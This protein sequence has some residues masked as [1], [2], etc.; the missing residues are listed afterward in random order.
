V[1]G[2]T[3]VLM[4]PFLIHRD[5]RFHPQPGQFNPHSWAERP[6]EQ[7]PKYEYLPFSE[8][9]RSCI[10]QHYAWL[11]GIMVLA[12]IAQSWRIHLVPGHPV[13]M[14]QLLNL[15]P[16]YGMMMQLHRRK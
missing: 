14:A 11:E 7:H 10:G 15:R 4:S 12:S 16:K 9:P 5:S 3:I 1:P 6:G 13:E 2:G 8:G